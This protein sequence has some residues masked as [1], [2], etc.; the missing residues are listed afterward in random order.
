MPWAPGLFSP[1]AILCLH[2]WVHG[3]PQIDL[4]KRHALATRTTRICL[5]LCMFFLM[6][7]SLINVHAGI[8]CIWS[9]CLL[10]LSTMYTYIYIYTLLILYITIHAET[11]NMSSPPWHDGHPSAPASIAQRS[12]WEASWGNS[13]TDPDAAAGAECPNSSAAPLRLWLR[14]KGNPP[15]RYIQGGNP[16]KRVTSKL[17]YKN[18][19]YKV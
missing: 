12:P 6:C 5:Y 9:M 4:K 14:P 19:S 16:K 7:S 8:E 18:I 11:T 10:F 1:P 15:N 13:P 17:A 3:C 2:V